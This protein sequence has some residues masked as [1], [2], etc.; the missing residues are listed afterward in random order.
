MQCNVLCITRA[1]SNDAL[2]LRAPRNCPRAKGETVPANRPAGVNAVCVIGVRVAYKANGASAAESEA[3]G[4]GSFEIPQYADPRRPVFWT[5]AVE[6]GS[7]TANGKGNVGAGH[8]RDVVEA[9]YQSTVRRAVHPI[10]NFG[11][12]W[13][14]WV[15]AAKLEAGNHRGITWVCVGLAKTFDDAV[16]EGGLGEGDGPGRPVATDG[17]SQC[18]L[19]RAQFGYVPAGFEE[20]LEPVV[21]LQ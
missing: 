11:R 15:R 9:A 12:W 2:F 3:K 1:V 8:H 16:D 6:E 17:Y 4:A 13:D 20:V 18:E 19:G 7:E 21:F 5:V 14:G 10:F